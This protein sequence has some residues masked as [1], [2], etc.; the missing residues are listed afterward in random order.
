MQYACA[1]SLISSVVATGLLINHASNSV[2]LKKQ[3]LPLGLEKGIFRVEVN[4]YS[5]LGVIPVYWAASSKVK[6]SFWHTI[7]FLL[8][9]NAI[10]LI[11]SC[12]IDAARVWKLL[13]DC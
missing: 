7:K 10:W 6:I 11:S 9:A 3:F 8:M 4:L 13:A 2:R 5:A 1:R 12:V